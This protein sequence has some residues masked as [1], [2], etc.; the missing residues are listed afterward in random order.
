MTQILAFAGTKQSG[1]TSGAHFVSAYITSQ[2]ARLNM[3]EPMFRTFDQNERGKII[4]PISNED[5]GIFDFSR[6]D[7]E[8]AEYANQY[9]WPYSK[10]Y[11][12]AEKLKEICHKVFNIPY[13]QIYGSDAEKSL[14][15]QYTWNTFRPDKNGFLSGREF[16]QEFGSF[17]RKLYPSIWIDNTMKMIYED[18]SDIAIIDDCRH[19]NEVEVLRNEGALIVK[20]KR[21]I[22]DDKHSSEDEIRNAPDEL[23]DL[24]IPET[25][26]QDKNQQ[27][28]DFL[29][30][31]GWFTK[32]IPLEV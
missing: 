27:V 31:K 5:S 9:I 29:Y 23:F 2:I 20:L 26:I 4:V 1:K 25:S 21:D 15:T 13:N 12:F 16:M 7:E 17:C 14:P 19:L 3:D 28:L 32:H 30:E 10:I 24:V 6:R 11:N 18:G 8:F 22:Y